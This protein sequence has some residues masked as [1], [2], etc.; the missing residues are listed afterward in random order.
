ME[1][2]MQERLDAQREL[3]KQIRGLNNL[4]ATGQCDMLALYEQL[5]G[6]LGEYLR[7]EDDVSSPGGS[8]RK[9]LLRQIGDLSSMHGRGHDMVL[10]RSYQ[11]LMAVANQYLEDSASNDASQSAHG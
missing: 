7:A 8:L 2:H 11:F 10:T 4:A 1:S 5:A 3:M 9:R 6:A